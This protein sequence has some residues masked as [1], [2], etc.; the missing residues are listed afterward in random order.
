M[1]RYFSWSAEKNKKLREERGISFEEIVFHIESGD[2]LAVLDHPNQ[3]RYPGQRL[4]VVAV[5]NYAW[6]VP[7]VESG[8][9]IFL[10][11]I[12]PSR[13]ATREYLRGES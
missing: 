7:A 8:R 1:V 6:L 12:I 2:L 3:K 13:K 11:T 4:L 10:K 5:G 9:E